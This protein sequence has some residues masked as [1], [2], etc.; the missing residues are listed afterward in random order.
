MKRYFA[1]TMKTRG[2]ALLINHDSAVPGT[3]FYY[4]NLRRFVGALSCILEFVFSSELLM[5]EISA[6]LVSLI[7]YHLESHS[8]TQIVRI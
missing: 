1:T 8:N 4:L 5:A 2:K 7:E 3:W 6:V